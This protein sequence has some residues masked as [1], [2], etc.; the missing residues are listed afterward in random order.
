MHLSR[1]ESRQYVETSDR[2]HSRCV[3]SCAWCS[4]LNL[5]FSSFCHP[6]LL[7]DHMTLARRSQEHPKSDSLFARWTVTHTRELLSACISVSWDRL[8][9]R[10]GFFSAL[11][12]ARSIS[13]VCICKTMLSLQSF[14]SGSLGVSETNQTERSSYTMCLC[15]S[16]KSPGSRSTWSPSG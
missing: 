4:E 7:H 3:I 16:V 14:F 11:Y 8:I 5:R 6:G 15:F 9:W 1:G 2:E 10:W 12:L 13:R